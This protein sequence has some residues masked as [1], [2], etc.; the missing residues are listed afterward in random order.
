MNF[1]FVAIPACTLLLLLPVSTVSAPRDDKANVLR[2]LAGRVGQVLGASSACPSVS[3][4]RI[5]KVADRLADA[6]KAG[7]SSQEEST[8]IFETFNSGS[9][10]GARAI[11]AAKTD[12][13]SD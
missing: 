2:G 12:L 1:R 5:K 8:S 4:E 6:I 10:E 13:R 3:R 11:A 9:L 7:T